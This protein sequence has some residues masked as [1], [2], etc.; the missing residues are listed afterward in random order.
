MDAEKTFRDGFRGLADR[1]PDIEPIDLD[2]I[3]TTT[4]AAGRGWPRWVAA[5]AGVV[6]VVAVGISAWVWRGGQ[7]GPAATPSAA[8]LV[9]AGT[10]WRAIT[11]AGEPAV[12]G[13]SGVTPTLEFATD[14]F[15]AADPCNV[16]R[17]T[18]Q[19]RGDRLS[20][21]DF[22]MTEMGCG[23]PAVLV[24]QQTYADA[25]RATHSA[26]Q[27]GE[28]LE[29]LGADG[30]VLVVFVG[31]PG[32]APTDATEVEVRLRN[33][34][35]QRFDKVEVNFYDGP[36]VDYGSLAP[37]ESSD[38]ET[39]RTRAYSYAWARVTIGAEKLVFQPTDSVGETP[40]SPGRYTYVLTISDGQLLIEL[41]R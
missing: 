5:A 21:G 27:A 22:A 34:T 2:A 32:S 26:R 16:G 39:P 30:A 18:Y 13:A 35:N 12:E 40:L 10:T 7:P 14:T 6:L 37:G 33:A 23:P 4:S 29:L 8:P 24:Q 1:A 36:V 11:I 41:E 19:L 3:E 28:H 15:A 20:F 38:Y 9:L 17:G 31:P 25:L